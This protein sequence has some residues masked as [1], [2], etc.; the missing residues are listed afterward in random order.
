MIRMEV[1]QLSHGRLTQGSALAPSRSAC[2]QE[3]IEAST[4]SQRKIQ[5][6]KGGA[7]G[8]QRVY[9][10]EGEGASENPDLISSKIL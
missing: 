8:E 6:E 9:L 2:D 4:A 10:R 3:I 7:K 5:A 1:R